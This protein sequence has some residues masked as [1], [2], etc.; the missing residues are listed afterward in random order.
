MKSLIV[1]AQF[2]T[3][4]PIKHNMEVS[5]KDFGDSQKAFIFV[6][7]FTGAIMSGSYYILK[8]QVPPLVLGVVLLVLEIV[9]NGGLLL[10]GFMDTSDGIFSAKPRERA[11]EIMKDSRVG[12]HSVTTVLLLFLVKFAVYASLHHV[13]NPYLFLLLA[14]MVG[15]WFMMFVIT[16]FPYA[17]SEGIGKFFKDQNKLL[18]F[19]VSTFILLLTSILLL[20]HYMIISGII[21]T[22]L[23]C[24][25]LA[26]KINTFLGGHTGDTYGAMSET[27]QAVFM[28]IMFF[29]L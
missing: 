23:L 19:W 17:R 6:A 7:L 14:P 26:V 20:P 27:A 22:F 24:F 10:D 29:L 21:I 9:I 16:F 12:A 2:L 5:D 15:K 28:L 11:L 3:R 18:Y 4:I 1:A 25:A 13:W 8:F